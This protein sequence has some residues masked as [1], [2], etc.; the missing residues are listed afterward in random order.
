MDWLR[1]IVE[2]PRTERFIMALI[3]LNAIT[4]GLET[5]ATAMENFGTLLTVID[6]LVIMVFVIEILARFAVQRGAF[7][8][9]GWNWFDMT[10][11]GIALAPATAAFSVL[12]ALR[13]LRL[14]R[15]ITAV[16][17]LQRVVGGLIGALPGMGS[18]LLLIA[19]IFYVCAVMAVNLYGAQYPELFGTLG[20]SLFTLFTIMTLEGW[21]EGV[22]N[23]IMET[24]P[25]AWLFFIPFIIITTFW[26][27]NLFI[28]IIVNAMQEE[29]SKAEAE[30][31][32][33]ERAM[34]QDETTPLL[35]EMRQIK[36]ELAALRKEV[37]GG[38]KKAARKRSAKQPA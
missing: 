32:Q 2:D 27:L 13:V 15:L 37:G 16:P 11:V 18:I 4:L 24:N 3:V 22:V 35:Q 10:V 9:D 20:A 38:V 6:R 25:Y 7:F 34:M 23:P 1:R 12:R 26:V 30:E 19:L 36:A 8:K 33:A 14:L 29:H 31:R 28:G 17:A 5:S 21:V